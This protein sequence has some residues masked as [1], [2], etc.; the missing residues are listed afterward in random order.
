MNHKLTKIINKY[1]IHISIL[2]ALSLLLFWLL[3]NPVK[4]FEVRIAGLDNRPDSIKGSNTIVKIGEKFKRY[5]SI[6][7][8]LKGKWTRFRGADFDNI[9]K[10]GIKLIDKF[11]KEGPKILWKKELGEGHAAPVIYNGK[12]YILDYDEDKKSDAL[13]CFSL[14]TGTE[15]WRRWYKVHVKRNHGMSRTVPAINEKYIVTIGPRGHV[16]CLN[17]KNGDFLWG[18]DLVKE[19]NTEIPFWYT[20]QCPII[21]KDTAIIA[22]G[23][24]NL[25]IAVNCADGKVV[26]KTE[27]PK[28]W[29]MSH[30]SIMPM[31]I[32]NKKMYVYAAVGGI[33]GV[34]AEGDD[35]GKILWQSNEF[36]PTVVAPSPLILNNGLVF[37]TAGYGAGAMLFKIKKKS[38]KYTVKIIEKYK[39]KNG[40]A[41]EQQT[42]LLYKNHVFAVLPKDAGS[43]RKQF[44][45]SKPD[46]FKKI[47]WTSGK[48]QR[49]GLGPYIIADDKF[50]ILND[51]GTLTI[52]KAS[53]KKFVLLDKIKIIDGQ[54]AWGPFAIADG[55]LILRDSKLMVCID[56]RK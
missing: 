42:P 45:C 32:E 6:N 36:S 37:M 21:D 35:I 7:S 20:G 14:E 50:F 15:L 29:K 49:F 16:M 52:A 40:I 34:S 11:G 38:K 1:I 46:N 18:I 4:N 3:Y 53:T 8:E 13:R 9:N 23:G 48:T 12:V 25:M 17:R 26:W 54:D 31:T 51:D 39:P 22:P 2:T 30:S 10:D 19:Y 28:K 56:L 41:S 27:N 24:K 55:I 33:C 43:L 44:V 47:L 5:L